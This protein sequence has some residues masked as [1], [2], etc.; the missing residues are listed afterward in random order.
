MNWPK[1]ELR[2]GLPELG[3]DQGPFDWLIL[4][5]DRLV[6]AGVL[7]AVVFA[8]LVAVELVV[9][10]A[11]RWSVPLL[12][13]YS[14][15]VGGN[16]TLITLVLSINQLVLSRQLSSP[17]ELREQIREVT[18]YRQEVQTASGGEI[19]PVTPSD[20][21]AQLL[22]NTDEQVKQLHDIKGNGADLDGELDD[23]ATSLENHMEGVSRL[24]TD[25]DVGTFNALSATLNTNYGEQIREV[26][27]LAQR[28]REAF[29]EDERAELSELVS[30]LRQIDVARQYF[31]TLFMQSELASLSRILLYVGVPAEIVSTV[32]L[33]AAAGPS[34]QSFYTNVP[35]LLLAGTVA[36]G[37][38]PLAVLFAFV[39]RIATVAQRT[40]AI[41]PFTTHEQQP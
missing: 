37:F 13:V 10:R 14:A 19:A 18:R 15:Q 25:S 2:I 34:A 32:M 4:N 38:A 33:V 6:V 20:F 7:L 39:L 21:L 17:G 1:T 9:L 31:K 11:V 30:R 24:L 23:L 12:Y 5:G 27:L 3:D 16:L 28:H 26:Q 29:T 8:L 22:E 40:A 41:T 36:V 35:P